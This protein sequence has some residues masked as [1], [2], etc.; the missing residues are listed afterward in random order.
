MKSSK[1]K[2]EPMPNDVKK[3]VSGRQPVQSV[4]LIEASELE[5]NAMERALGRLLVEL[6]RQECARRSKSS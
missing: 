2:K 6:V 4:R 1:H 3:H 5:S